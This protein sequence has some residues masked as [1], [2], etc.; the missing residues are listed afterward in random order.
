MKK[1]VKLVYFKIWLILLKR[2]KRK[3]LELE[4]TLQLS[5][6]LTIRTLSRIRHH[7]P[8]LT[9]QL[10]LLLWLLPYLKVPIDNNPMR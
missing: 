10:T 1:I 5:S 9:P 7:L 2:Q 8:Q 4:E 3:Y 6:H